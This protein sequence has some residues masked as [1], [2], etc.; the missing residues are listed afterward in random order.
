MLMIGTHSRWQVR[1]APGDDAEVVR[2]QAEGVMGALLDIEEQEKRINSA[3]VSVDL[4]TL[5]VEIDLAADA[6]DFEEAQRLVDAAIK[7]AIS[8]AGG[9][10]LAEHVHPVEK[11]AELIPA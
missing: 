4:G 5:T 11:S 9:R 7:Q 3:A 10:V 1:L 6:D 8:V 2:R